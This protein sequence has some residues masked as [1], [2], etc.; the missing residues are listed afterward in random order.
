MFVA[1]ETRVMRLSEA[2]TIYLSAAASFGVAH[3][4]HGRSRSTRQPLA[5]A[6][7]TGIA[8]LWPLAALRLLMERHAPATIKADESDDGDDA[9]APHDECQVEQAKRALINSL[10]AIEDLLER[11][12]GWH[13]ETHR[14]E[15][16]AARECV[17]RYAGLALAS[18]TACADDAPTTRE[19]ELYQLAGRTNEDLLL[20]GLCTHRRNVLRLLAHRERARAELTH[21][22]AAVRELAH[23][24]CPSSLQHAPDARRINEA[25]LQT[26]AHAIKLFSLL[27]DSDAAIRASRLHDAE[28]ARLLS[29]SK[30]E[31]AAPAAA[32]GA[33]A[34]GEGLCTT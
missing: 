16:F 32:H 10:H 2:V 20:A 11:T 1:L 30:I 34:Q 33:L 6:R 18:S 7:A 19:L 24:L 4:L 13:T 29:P 23:T 31:H 15:M 21:T 28:G 25:L 3:F 26:L 27:D 14:H 12:S 8:L 17:E 5:L 9:R 22:L